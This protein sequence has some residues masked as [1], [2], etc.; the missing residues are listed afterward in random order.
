MKTVQKVSLTI[1]VNAKGCLHF[2]CSYSWVILIQCYEHVFSIHLL[3]RNKQK[4]DPAGRPAERYMRAATLSG[5]A[6]VY[7]CC[8][9]GVDIYGIYGKEKRRD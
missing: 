8:S 3:E 6:Y 1:Y 2:S 4:L 7:L 5:N 9:P